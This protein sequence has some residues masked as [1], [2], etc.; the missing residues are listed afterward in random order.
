MQ[1]RTLFLSGFVLFVLLSFPLINSGRASLEMWSQSYGG[2]YDDRAYSLV[3]ASDGGYAIAGSTRTFLTG[4]VDF[5]L[6]KTDAYGNMEWN[7]TYGEGAAHSLVKKS[8]GGYALAGNRRLVKTDGY[9][10][11]E[12]NQTYGGAGHDHAYSLVEA[13]DGGY[14]IAGETYSFGAGDYDFWLVKTDGYGNMEWNQ[15]YGGAGHDHAYSL[16][17]ASDGGYA[18]AGDMHSTDAGI[19]Y[20]AF[21]VKTDEHGIIPEFPSWIILPL[22]IVAIFVT[23]MFYRMQLKKLE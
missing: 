11:M 2:K 3:E 7:Q 16:V 13:S 8:D 20:D 15:T 22:F 23:V 9:G 14:A 5:W 1:H 19:I 18:I 4:S 17:E 10:N 21:L 6:V 12:W